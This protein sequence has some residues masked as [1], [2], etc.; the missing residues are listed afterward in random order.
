M[1]W[2]SKYISV[3]EKPFDEVDKNI[4]A[5]IRQKTDSFACDKPLVSVVIIAHNE[6]TRLLSCI[7]S[8]VDN[9]HNFPIEIIGVDNC[10][11]DQ[12]ADVY[13]AAGVKY[14][15]EDKPGP[16]YARQCGLEHALGKYHIC[17]DG[18]S[19]YPPLYIQTMISKLEQ[20]QVVAVFGLWSFIPDAKNTAFQLKIYEFLRDIH[21]K[22]QSR[23]RPELSVRG[24]AFAFDTELGRK[25]GFRTDIRRGEDGSLLLELKK[26]G[27][28]L[29]VTNKKARIVTSSGT[30]N[31]DGSLFNSLRKRATKYFKNFSN[32]FTKETKY[33]DEDS[34]L[35]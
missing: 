20:V 22:I 27:K 5:D 24:M 8:L 14:F 33:T 18:D 29:F 35:L 15:Y 11:T 17:I 16:G 9:K 6:A 32:Y 25:I 19:I 28:I 26:Y 7:W 34:N 31:S 21:L 30:L 10:S 23:K 2:Y 13:K 12:T 3:F 1:V 4:I